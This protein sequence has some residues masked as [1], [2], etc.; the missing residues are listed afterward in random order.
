MSIDLTI[1]PCDLQSANNRYRDIKGT[2]PLMISAQEYDIEGIVYCLSNGAN[3]NIQDREGN[4]VFHYLE[5]GL[6]KKA[7]SRFVKMNQKG[8]DKFRICP[9]VIIEKILAYNPDLSL[10]NKAGVSAVDVFRNSSLPDD[11]LS[12]IVEMLERYIENQSLESVIESDDVAA[13][14]LF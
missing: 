6:Q 7:C 5:K 4:S 13:G 3:V 2:S 1:K 10:P 12:Q 9:L 14:V 11:R 8:E